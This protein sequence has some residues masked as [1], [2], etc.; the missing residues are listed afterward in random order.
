MFLASADLNFLLRWQDSLQD[1][2]KERTH[3]LTR[4]HTQRVPVL[5]Q[6]HCLRCVTAIGASG[7]DWTLPAIDV[8]ERQRC[9]R[10]SVPLFLENL[11]SF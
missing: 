1:K 9:L 4:T 11:D 5:V 2:H 10:G 3:A 6:L 8:Y 7:C